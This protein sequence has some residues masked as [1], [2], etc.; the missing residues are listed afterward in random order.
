MWSKGLI[1]TALAVYLGV[2]GCAVWPPEGGKA[3]AGES[4]PGGV[5]SVKDDGGPPVYRT[6]KLTGLPYR[7]VA[8]Q[9]Q[10]VDMID[11]YEKSIDE[12]AAIGADTVSIVV[13]CRQENGSSARIF[14][15]LRMTPSP[16]MLKRLIGHAKQRN[17]RVVLMPIVLLD[18]PRGNEWRGTIK[19]ELWEEWFESYR[20]MMLHYAAVAAQNDVDLFV[21]GSELVS[22]ETKIAEWTKTIRAIRKVYKGQ[23]TYSSNWDHYRAVPFW[24]QLDLIG[25]NSYW[26][27]GMVGRKTLD[28]KEITPDTI[29]QRWGEIQEDLFAFTKSTGKPLVLL[30]AGWC[31][32]SNAAHEPWDYTQETVGFDMDLQ[33]KLYEGFFKAWWGNSNLGGF[34]LWEWTP[35]DGGTDDRGYT[36]E[37][38]PAEK[39]MKEWFKK[40]WTTTDAH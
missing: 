21:V 7:G 6:Q 3:H 30:E 17:L 11:A 10:H 26:N 37:G 22:S 16:E 18:N 39:V 2:V 36:P 34:M 25:M 8:M 13:D 28:R 14:M 27:L 15:D 1:F 35:G 19:P 40:P 12:V 24:D 20:A 31:S 4:G 5:G 33:K 23:I 29:K 9:V 38:K 32:V